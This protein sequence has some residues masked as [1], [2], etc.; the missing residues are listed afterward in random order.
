MIAGKYLIG[1]DGDRLNVW[2]LRPLKVVL[3]S[4]FLPLLWSLQLQQK[5][6]EGYS[7]FEIVAEDEYRIYISARVSKLFQIHTHYRYHNN[8]SPVFND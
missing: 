4:L 7:D 1:L 5:K 6:I 3:N 8:I 2:G